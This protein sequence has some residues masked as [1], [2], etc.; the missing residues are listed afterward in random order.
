MSTL[1]WRKQF[2]P[3]NHDTFIVGRSKRGTCNECLKIA[4]KEYEESVKKGHKAIPRVQFCPYGHDTFITG[5]LGGMCA[6]CQREHQ[7]EKYVPHPR[8]TPQ[9]C[10]QG[11]DTLICGRYTNSV[12]RQCVLDYQK[13]FRTEHKEEKAAADRK[14]RETHKEELALKEL[15]YYRKNRKIIDAKKKIYIAEHPEIYKLIHLRQKE[16]R[17]KRVAKFGRKGLHEF[18]VNMPKGMTE[19]HIIPLCGDFVSG[20]HVIWNLQ[21]LSPKDNNFKS[22]DID[23]IWASEWYGQ[24]LKQEGLII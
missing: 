5:R 22:N 2:C 20:L 7:R 3:Q 17:G 19:D 24:L 14:Y 12:C 18:Y 1:G 6:E 9:F 11:H 13:E 8:I 10:P 23:L 15:E 16:K 4:R 21:Y